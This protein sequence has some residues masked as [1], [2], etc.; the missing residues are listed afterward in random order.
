MRRLS[1]L[2]I[3]SF[4]LPSVVSASDWT[5]YRGPEGLGVLA[6]GL[7]AGE[8]ELALNSTWVRDLGSGYSGV[9]THGNVLVTAFAAGD[10]DVV[11]AF[12]AAAGD[13]LWRYTLEP[14]YTGHDGSHDGP[15][16]TP[17]ISG[18][19][20]FVLGAWGQVA[21]L[22]LATG[23]EAW[24]VHLVEDLEATK[25]WYGFGSSP[26]AVDGNVLVGADGEEGTLIA[27]DR[28]TG[29]VSWRAG[30]DGIEY[31]S[32]V[33]L[34]LAGRRQVV[35]GGQATIFAVEPET[36]EMLW[37]YEHEGG[38]AIG[39]SSL[40]VLP[41]ADDRLFI[42]H[43]ARVSSLIEVRSGEEGYT[44][45][46]IWEDKALINSYIPPIESGGALF[47]YSTRFLSAVDPATGE[48]LFRSREPGDGFPIV[49]EDQMMILTKAGTLHLGPVS[50]E[51]WNETTSLALFDKHSWT[52]P[53]Y[54]DGSL[55]LRSFSQLA[56]VD[57][58][59]GAEHSGLA[60]EV[61]TRI[62]EISSAADPSAAADRIWAEAAPPWVDGNQ[63][64]FAWRGEAADVGIAGDMI[65]I[66]DEAPMHPIEGTDVFWWSGTVPDGMRFNYTFLI[67]FEPTLDPTNP[68]SVQSQIYGPDM[69]FAE[70]DGVEMSWFALPGWQEPEH[71]QEPPAG[72]PRGEV[73]EMEV[74][75]Q[76]PARDEE[77]EAPD[78]VTIPVAVWTPPG[79]GA[80]EEAYPVA[81]VID[82]EAR[83][84]GNWT[85]TLDRLVGER[86]A[87]AVV[88]FIDQPRLPGPLFGQAFKE[89]IVPQVESR[90][91]IRDEAASRAVVGVGGTSV[92]ALVLGL[93]E[94]GFS[95]RVAVQSIH[96]IEAGMTPIFQI[97]DG[98]ESVDPS[99][100]IYLE[101]GSLDLH[102]FKEGWDTR[103]L[104][105]DFY[106]DL[107]SRGYN[108]SGGEVVDSL[109]WASWRNRTDRV[110]QTLFPL[111]G[112]EGA[113]DGGFD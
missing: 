111:E 74:A 17:L 24:S 52:A 51:G 75:F 86:F 35:V 73:H 100:E 63:V 45:E 62:V 95:N 13:E 64:T 103:R 91:R 20:V 112:G 97:L 76:P 1:I 106:A 78:P 88:V 85:H 81:Y 108:V 50:A 96:T 36:G 4:F 10:Q 38:G 21:A 80:G 70:G 92:G 61:P 30:T 68:R 18:D 11:A 29:E 55:Y 113:A 105:S 83:R 57:L 72:H 107:E 109:G 34:E 65:G 2:V 66:R 28:E 27:L 94:P 33:L 40:T 79:Y 5:G 14:T 46:K 89:E 15:I 41:L 90:F 77:S 59:R 104:T 12:D 67:D 3:A 23:E 58:V 43:D 87:P 84:T 19:R 102:A 53:A 98:A 22:D 9:S 7:P 101:W 47:G 71:L 26:L 93:S 54:A 16:A 60:L 37:S 39:A 56:R 32:P 25:P 99:I 6:E 82:G 49:V 110:L 44:V 48:I 8:G 42:D 31:Q 69:N